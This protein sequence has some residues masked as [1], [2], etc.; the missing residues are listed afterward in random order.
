MKRFDSIRAAFVI[1][2][3]GA[4]PVALADPG[5]I[6]TTGWLSL[7]AVPLIVGVLYLVHRKLT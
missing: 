5:G 7:A 3:L 4:S 6:S 1:A 2:G